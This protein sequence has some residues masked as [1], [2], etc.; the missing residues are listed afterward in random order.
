MTLRVFFEIGFIT[1]I[2]KKRLSLI[3]FSNSLLYQDNNYFIMSLSLMLWK[4]M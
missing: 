1:W 3:K 4:V 2:M